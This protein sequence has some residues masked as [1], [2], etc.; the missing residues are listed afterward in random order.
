MN[1]QKDARW[2]STRLGNC[3]DTIGSSGCLIT[4]LTNLAKELGV[5]DVTPSW[6]NAWLLQHAGYSNGCLLI[7]PKGAE[8]VGIV[9]KEKT[10]IDPKHICICETDHYKSKGVPQ[11][12]FV[13]SDKMILDPL[14]LKP[15]WKK[16]PYK[17]VSYRIFTVKATKVPL[18]QENA[19]NDEITTVES[20][21]AFSCESGT[22]V[23]FTR[24]RA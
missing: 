8:G 22:L 14:D 18:S 5:S 11:H 9:F 15:E 4:S 21:G 20:I 16:N 23:A 7:S 17:I 1:S 2:K 10:K 3:K 19:P 13:Y 6:L 12:F 24:K